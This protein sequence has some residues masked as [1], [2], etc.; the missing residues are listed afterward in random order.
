[1]TQP[2]QDQWVRNPGQAAL[3][4]AAAGS[5]VVVRRYPGKEEQAF[6]DFQVDAAQMSRADWFPTA[7]QYIPGSW[8]PAAILLAVVLFFV[9]FGIFILIYMVLV[10]PDGTLVVTYQYRGPIAPKPETVEAW[11]RRVGPVAARASIEND[12]RNQDITRTDC[13]ARMS[14]IDRLKLD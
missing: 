6:V 13:A 9:I 10:K 4:E 14:V 1:M 12:L 8:G 11:I 3:I 7:Q 5:H 2:A